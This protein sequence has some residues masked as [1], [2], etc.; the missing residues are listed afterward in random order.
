MAS[1]PLSSAATPP[2]GS[3]ARGANAHRNANLEPRCRCI[4]RPFIVLGLVMRRLL[5]LMTAVS[6]LAVPASAIGSTKAIWGPLEMPNGSSALP[7][8]EDLGVD[9]LQVIL[10][11]G[12]VA[13][14]RP[15]DPTNPGGPAYTWP[16][17]LDEAV[18]SA[19]AYGIRVALLVNTSPRWANGD[20]SPEWAPDNRAYADFLT[21]ASRRYPEVRHWMIWGEANR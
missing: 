9:Y 16:A 5:A 15:T 8:Y 13:T 4:V 12:T 10:R 19:G 21:A 6:C 3:E 1:M 11:W 14:S 20:R 17:G 2:L 7:V 18:R